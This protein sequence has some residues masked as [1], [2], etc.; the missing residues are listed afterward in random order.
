MKN[1]STSSVRRMVC[2]A[3]IGTGLLGLGAKPKSPESQ[4]PEDGPAWKL[5]NQVVVV[6]VEDGD[7]SNDKRFRHLRQLIS[8]IADAPAKAVVFD[9]NT[10]PGYSEA[11]ARYLMEELP[12]VRVPSVS[13]VNPSALGAGALIALGSDS[14]YLSPVAVIGGAE[15]SAARG[16][17][18]ARGPDAEGEGK[19]AGKTTAAAS[20][21]GT[22]QL[23]VLKAQARSLAKRNGHRPEVAEAFIDSGVEVRYGEELV[24]TKGDLLTLT[25]DEAVGK[26]QDGKPVFGTALVDSLDDLLG[27][28]GLGTEDGATVFTPEGYG[29]HLAEQRHGKTKAGKPGSMDGEDDDKAAVEEEEGR[30]PLFGKSDS[31]SYE[32]KILVVPVGMDDLMITARF[33]FMKRVLKKAQLDGAEALIFDMNTPGGRVWETGELMMRE[34]QE[35]DF[36]T[37]TFVNNFAESGGCLVAIA[38]DHIY[39]RPAALIGSALPVT[40]TGDLEGN[41][42]QKVGEMLRDLVRSVARLKGHDPDVAEAFVTTDTEVVKDGIMISEMGTV[43]HLS[44]EEATMLVNGEPLLAKGIVNSI[45]EIIERE[46]L[47]GEV[48]NVVPLG[49]ERFAHWVQKFS[50]LL[51]I[52]G[53][54]GAYME[55]N[56]PGFGVPGVTSLLAFGLFFFGN[57]L[58][59]NLA[60]YELA[61]LLV[62]GLVLIGVEV[63]ILPGTLL[64]GLAGGLLVFLS[65]VLAMV[66][67][68]DF[69]S[70][71]QDLPRAPSWGELLAGPMLTF[72]LGVI[73]AVAIA[74]LFM[75]FLPSNRS[76][77]G[78]VLTTSLGSGG[79][80]EG[81]GNGGKD[82]GDP[83]IGREGVV[84]ADLRPAG[85]GMFGDKLLDIV[86]DGEFVGQG[87]RVRVVRREGA[88]I[89]VERVRE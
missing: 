20:P 65:L 66:D 29:Q 31:E 80:I 37:Y 36:P 46:E 19:A 15:P 32:G 35:V 8:D 27:L 51:I 4:S 17:P 82:A 74:A 83:L 85:K 86:A 70:Q 52:L 64:P 59:G 43:L 24:S 7:I 6:K 73:G 60:G 84:S 22:Q 38:T 62:L 50:F 48:L 67:R 56:A 41:M 21:V 57:H 42:K 47:G 81:T 10:G 45:D 68:F 72:L 39:M 69:Q 34:L 76:F 13:F 44:T 30:S 25:A 11:V 63:F 89:V 40:A 55:L 9:L 58:A 78:M 2:L 49:M 1:S 23:S 88:R 16:R 33:E 53:L 77:G 75:R 12:K 54:A 79:G 87:S 5:K 26:L 28:E 71:W 3:M 14:V 18:G 61:V